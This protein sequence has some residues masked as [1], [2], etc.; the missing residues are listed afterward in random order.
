MPSTNLY[1][2]DGTSLLDS[3][4]VYSNSG[5]TIPA[6][7]GYYS[8][9]ANIREQ[10]GGVLLPAQP[11]PGCGYPCQEGLQFGSGGKGLYIAQIDTGTLSSSVGAIVI[12][13]DPFSVPDGIEV[14]LDGV[15]YN[16]LSCQ[17]YGYIAA[18]PGLPTFT[19]AISQ[20]CGLDGNT[21]VASLPIFTRVGGVWTPNGSSQTV[22]ILPSQVILKPFDPGY[23]K[24]V[25]PKTNPLP[26]VLTIK[27]Y[28]P[29]DNTGF[30]YEAL[31]PDLL[32]SFKGSVLQEDTKDP[33]YCNLAMNQTYYFSRVTIPPVSNLSVH[34]WVF[35][36]PYGQN[37]LSDG[38]Y[39]VP[40]IYLTSTNDTI[41]VQNGVIIA[42]TDECP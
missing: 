2:L 41:E 4:G 20:D 11:C 5:L 24:M 31:C 23:L 15:I 13:F 36:D 34:D 33:L 25:V 28:G 10:V 9:G 3:T 42:I 8:D 38:F 16:E 35:S 40:S 22:T 6:S 1:F 14:E 27:F 7:D 21:T 18:P 26:S 37:K 12:T 17:Y 30:Q 29:C 19:G 32:D 39:K